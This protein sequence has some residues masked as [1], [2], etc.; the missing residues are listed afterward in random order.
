VSEGGL[1]IALAEAAISAGIGAELEL[2]DDALALFGE[3]G[4]RALLASSQE[5]PFPRIGSVAGSTLLGVRID[6]L[7]RAYE[8][9]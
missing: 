7:R 6:D 8:V 9:T 2:P 4:G 5:L 3:G 1:A